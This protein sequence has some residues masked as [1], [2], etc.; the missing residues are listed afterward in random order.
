MT[1]QGSGESDSKMTQNLTLSQRKVILGVIFESVYL[2]PEK[3]LSHRK[4]HFWVRDLWPNGVSQI[5][6]SESKQIEIM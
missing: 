5:Q 1:F 3:F 4:C 2:D 6:T